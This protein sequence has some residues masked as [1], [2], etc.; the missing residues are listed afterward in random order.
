MTF[1]T[2]KDYDKEAKEEIKEQIKNETY[3]DNISV[4]E[5]KT[6]QMQRELKPDN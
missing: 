3:V 1:F 6:T 2:P 5:T 4:G